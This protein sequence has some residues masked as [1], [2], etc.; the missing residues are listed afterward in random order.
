MVLVPGGTF[1]SRLPTP[2]AA[3]AN[4]TGPDPKHL[5]RYILSNTRLSNIHMTRVGRPRFVTMKVPVP[6]ISEGG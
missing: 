1:G 6:A 4:E 3:T 2:S 5:N